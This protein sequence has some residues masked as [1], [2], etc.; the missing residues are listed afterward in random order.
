MLRA[1]GAS[2]PRPLGALH[3]T[4]KAY[5]QNILCY[6]TGEGVGEEWSGSLEEW[7][8]YWFFCYRFRFRIVS[9]V[10]IIFLV[11]FDELYIFF[12]YPC[13]SIVGYLNYRLQLLF[14]NDF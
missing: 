5:T 12:L 9:F 10:S 1:H 7:M 14:L 13:V 6:D 4:P 11:S 8:L 3:L 2:P